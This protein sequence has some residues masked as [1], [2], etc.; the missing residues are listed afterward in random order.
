MYLASC[1]G[2]VLYF[3]SGKPPGRMEYGISNI[4]AWH[5]HSPPDLLWRQGLERVMATQPRSSSLLYPAWFFACAICCSVLHKTLPEAGLQ[6]TTAI[7]SSKASFLWEASRR[8][9]NV[10]TPRARLHK[11][12]VSRACTVRRTS[13][14]GIPRGCSGEAD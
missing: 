2:T 4:V 12:Q 8:R 6:V 11:F 9:V 5:T 14:S 1:P 10:R 13:D 3:A 7:L